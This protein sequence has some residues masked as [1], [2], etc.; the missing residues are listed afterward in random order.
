MFKA[1]DNKKKE[2][3]VKLALEAAEKYEK[4]VQEFK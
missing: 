4:Q 2:K 3:Y 1:L